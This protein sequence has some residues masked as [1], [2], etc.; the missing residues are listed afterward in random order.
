LLADASMRAM[1]SF[2]QLPLSKQIQPGYK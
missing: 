2:Y 1:K